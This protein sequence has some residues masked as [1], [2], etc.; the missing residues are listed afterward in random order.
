M[1]EAVDVLVVGG[2]PAG[3]LA[4]A[5]AART[6]AKVLLVDK[7]RRFGALPHC[8]EFV[9]RLLAREV[10]FPSRSQVQPVEGMLT[11]LENEE[12]FTPG[13]GWILDRQVFDHG[14]VLAA[15]QA[16][17]RVWAGAKLTGREGDTWDIQRGAG[18]LRVRPGAVVAADGAASA[19]ARLA[20]WPSQ[21]L[22]AGVQMQVP[23]ARPLERTMVFLEPAFRHGYAW[24]FPQGDAANLGLG[25]RG[26]AKPGR[27]LDNLRTKLIEQGMILPGVLALAGGAIPVSGPRRELARQNVLLAGDAAGLTHPVTGAGIPQAVFSGLEAGR[28]AVHLAGGR[29]EAGGEYQQ[30]VLARYG[31][32]LARGVA[33]RR[34][35]ELGWDNGGFS[36]LMAHTWPAW[37]GRRA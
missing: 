32:H 27:L 33:A 23:L 36:E 5:Q 31:G 25:C 30:K 20:G 24:L 16:G 14:L 19:T 17:A 13:P 7:K 4:A 15:A 6:G 3:A 1:P 12:F 21:A 37:S 11:R 35:M 2:G 22:L 10:T 28:A 29:A 18:T 26:D 8:A 34:E 9:P